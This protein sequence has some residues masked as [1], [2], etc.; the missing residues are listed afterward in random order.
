MEAFD[1]LV[2][3][4]CLSFLLKLEA[5]CYKILPIFAI[6]FAEAVLPT[7]FVLWYLYFLRLVCERKF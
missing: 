7:K 4:V 3:L 5:R 1:A 6:T 2:L